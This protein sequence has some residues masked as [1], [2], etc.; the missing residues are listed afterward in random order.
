MK[1]LQNLIVRLLK[2]ETLTKLFAKQDNGHA[3]FYSSN[4]G[5]GSFNT[6]NMEVKKQ[7]VEQIT[8]LKK[9]T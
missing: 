3:T 8:K 4:L 6:S 9:K 1:I 7:K 5:G 2:E